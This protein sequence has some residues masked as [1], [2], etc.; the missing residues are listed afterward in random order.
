MFEA[1]ASR[2][3]SGVHAKQMMFYL[4]PVVIKRWQRWSERK[5]PGVVSHGSARGTVTKKTILF[6]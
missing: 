5:E 3:P 4:R 2:C 1:K 6:S